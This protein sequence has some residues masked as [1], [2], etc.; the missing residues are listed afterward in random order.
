MGSFSQARGALGKIARFQVWWLEG[1]GG[2]LCNKKRNW[3]DSGGRRQVQILGGLVVRYC[4]AFKGEI[5]KVIQHILSKIDNHFVHGNQQ[6]HWM[7]MESH[8]EKGS[9]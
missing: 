7:G 1:F 9:F 5:P 6:Q 2:G 8:L 4:H 3:L